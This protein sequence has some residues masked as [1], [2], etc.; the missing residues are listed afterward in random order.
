MLTH[1][2][3]A[4]KYPTLFEYD[5]ASGRL[6]AFVDNQL[7]STMRKCEAYFVEWFMNELEPRSANSRWNLDFGIWWHSVMEHF[8]TNKI[9]HNQRDLDIEEML[10]IAHVEWRELGLDEKFSDHFQYKKLGGFAGAA[11]MVTNFVLSFGAGR[12]TL[13]IIATEMPF[14]RGREV[15]LLVF[16]EEGRYQLDVFLVGRPDVIVDNGRSVGPLDFKTTS[17]FKGTEHAAYK[18]YDALAGY[19]YAINK[20]IGPQMA[21]LGK[22]CDTAYVTCIL[23]STSTRKAPQEFFKRFP[24]SYTPS[25]LEEYRKR[26]IATA[27]RM[28]E[29]VVLGDNPQWNTTMCSNDFYHDCAYKSIHNIAPE[30]REAIINTAYTRIERWNPQTRGRVVA[31]GV[32]A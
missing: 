10:S 2:E 16:P 9:T 8:Y 1:K 25:E 7:L 4:A 28:Y 29:L 13:N 15:P 21:A 23:K 27:M 24:I 26:Q 6:V 11:I 18:P 14:G 31:Q 30:H 17:V 22:K 20:L 32:E 3:A 5:A 12:E 19:V